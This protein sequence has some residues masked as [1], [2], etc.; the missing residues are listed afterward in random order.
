MSQMK[1]FQNL[2]QII[3]AMCPLILQGQKIFKSKA[4]QLKSANHYAEASRLYLGLHED[5]DS[6]ALV[7]A[8]M[9]LYHGHQFEEALPLFSKADSLSLMSNA[10]EIFAYFECLKWMKRYEDADKLILKRSKDKI[11]ARELALNRE[12]LP[13]YEKLLN[14]N[15]GEVKP[16]GFNTAFSE[17]SPT[18]YSNWLYFVSTAP[19]RVKTE[20]ARINNQPYYSLYAVPAS[21]DLNGFISPSGSYEQPEKTIRYNGIEE[22]SLPDGLNQKYHDGPIYAAPSGKMVFFN[23]NWSIKKRPRQKEL[24]V[25]LLMYYIIK[26]G[27]TWSR[28]IP[29]PFNSFQYSN[30]HPFYDESTST[31]YFSSNMPGGFGGFDIWKS[32]FSAGKWSAP[33]NLGNRINSPKS[34]VFPCIAPD[35]TL[36]FSSNGWPGLGGLDLF[37]VGNSDLSPTNMTA[38]LNSERDDFGLCFVNENLAYLTSNRLGGKGDDDIYLVKFNLGKLKEYMRSPDIVFTG[39]IKDQLSGSLLD[40]VRISLSGFIVSELVTGNDQVRISF[41]AEQVNALN[42]ELIIRYQKDGYQSKESRLSISQDH[43]YQFDL[44]QNLMPLEKIIKEQNVTGAIKSGVVPQTGKVQNMSQGNK[45]VGNSGQG[46]NKIISGNETVVL[47][48]TVDQIAS[49]DPQKFIVYFDYNKY[50]IRKDAAEVLAKVVYVL[51]QDNESSYVLLTGH[52]DSRGSS[53]YNDRLA[54]QRVDF[55]KNWLVQKG[56]APSRIRTESKGER[57][58]AVWCKETLNQERAQDSCLSPAEHQ[59]NR[60]VEIEFFTDPK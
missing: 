58:F 47:N 30:Q 15:S 12:K 37:M 29:L 14:Y 19:S 2:F 13:L 33:V 17:I 21:S 3:L 1:S 5:G 36:I 46:A 22:I 44:S 28:P 11:S 55:V 45:T 49:S 40:G 48:T 38:V 50:L 35:G 18:L 51:L 6:K 43:P 20:Y 39:L 8:A 9:S 60:R 41:P 54:G 31:L 25:N 59:L 26:N 16:L 34:E 27:N 10:E 52:T 23:T 32:T 53:I 56:I 4:D 7:E 42:S 24:E 57:Q